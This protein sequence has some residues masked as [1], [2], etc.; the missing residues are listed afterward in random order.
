[1]AHQRRHFMAT[2]RMIS[3]RTMRVE[4]KSENPF[5]YFQVFLKKIR[6]LK[7][8]KKAKK[9]FKILSSLP[10]LLYSVRI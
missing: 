10:I 1:M 5:G 2:V 6:K 8:V 7:I 9:Y 3:K 4:T